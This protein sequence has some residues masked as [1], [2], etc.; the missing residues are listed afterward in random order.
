MRVTSTIEPSSTEKI[1]SNLGHCVR[2]E[3]QDR[4]TPSKY[5]D[6]WYMCSLYVNQFNGFL[7]L[8]LLSLASFESPHSAIVNVRHHKLAT[9]PFVVSSLGL[10]LFC[11]YSQF[12]SAL[13]V[14]S[15]FP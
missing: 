13:A 15:S 7:P 8:G 10:T 4:S 14:S 6:A 11:F 5:F 3:L 1:I 2:W 9:W 12:Y